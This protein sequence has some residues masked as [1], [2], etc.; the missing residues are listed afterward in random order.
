MT[1]YLHLVAIQLRISIASAM[2]YRA[3][4]FME[5]ALSA[6]WLATTILPLKVVFDGRAAV[7][8]WT[9][10]SALIV[11]AYFVAVRAILEGMITPSLADLVTRVRN[12]SFDYVLLKPVDAQAMISASHYEPWRI[13]DLAG[14]LA[15]A[16]YAF[17][18]L[19]APP[20]WPDV[21]LG[22]VMFASGVAAAY[23]LWIICAALAFWVGRI[24]NLIYLLGA[25]FD[26]AR[27]PVSLLPGLWR[28]V[29]TFVIPL[30]IMTTYPAQALLGQLHPRTAIETVLG[31]AVMLGIS[32]LVWRTAIRSYTSASS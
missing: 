22:A 17:V 7:A 12:G 32:R 9:A 19:G 26:T 2:A 16:I 28:F 20:A 21:A 3:N 11:V 13:F 1:R 31:T 23:A 8:G 4:F 24:D 25:I 29:F 18:R 30:A 10:P 14:A 27:W 6:L 5:G 15:I